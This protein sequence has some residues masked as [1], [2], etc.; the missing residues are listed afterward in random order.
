MSEEASSLKLD[1]DKTLIVDMSRSLPYNPFFKYEGEIGFVLS[2]FI[3]IFKNVIVITVVTFLVILL[4]T[5]AT[6]TKGSLEDSSYVCIHRASV[7]ILPRDERSYSNIA[8]LHVRG[9]CILDPSAGNSQIPND[10]F[11]RAWCS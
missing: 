7:G 9:V 1:T 5:H 4:F 8:V 2:C 11:L 3:C 10:W 6:Q